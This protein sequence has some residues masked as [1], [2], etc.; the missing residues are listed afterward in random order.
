MMTQEDVGPV[1]PEDEAPI[2]ESSEGAEG[3]HC[4]VCGFG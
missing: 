2:E 4:A 3:K 1:T